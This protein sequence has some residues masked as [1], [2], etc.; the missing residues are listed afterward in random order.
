MIRVAPSVLS[1]DF[2][3]LAQEVDDV[4]RAGAEWLH[5]D[6]MDGAF[7]PNISMGFPVLQSL[8]KATELFLDVH[9]MVD[10][11]LRF[12][13]RFCAAGADLVNVHAEADSPENIR[14]ALER[15]RACGKK[16]GITVKPGTPIEAVLPYLELVDLVLVM[17]VEPGF[18]GQS[19]MADM[20][21]K[22]AAIRQQA[23]RRGL[24][25][26][27][28]VDG[29]ISEKTIGA[30]AKAGANVFVAGSAIFGA[31]DAAQMIT[32]LRTRAE[33]AAQ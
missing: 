1:A 23:D 13:E 6:V 17:T 15:V 22:V 4:K 8:R 16:A 33:Q 5:F 28:Q 29:G 26:D 3:R 12:V 14:A 21:P 20:M 31:P 24:S 2:A 11:P 9:L 27:I 10:R 19:F 7:V 30:A 18:G 25:L 32:S